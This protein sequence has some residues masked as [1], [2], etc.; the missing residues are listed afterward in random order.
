MT[1]HALFAISYRDLLK[2]LRDPT[3]LVWSFLFPVLLIG[4]FGG[5]MEANLGANT[6]FDFLA[7]TF[8]GVFAQ[9]IFMSAA[10]G[11]VSL[12][13]DRVSDFSQEVFVS[14]VSRYVIVLGK[15][16][17]ETIVAMPPGV[18]IL[19]FG[20][21]VG[22]ELSP[23]MM[24]QLVAVGVFGAVLGGAFGVAL[25]SNFSSRRTATQVVPFIMFPQFFLAGVFTPIRVLPWYLDIL[26]RLSPMRYA[27]DLARGIFFGART[28]AS[29]TVLAS[30]VTNLA[31]MAGMFALFVVVGTYRFV[32]QEQNR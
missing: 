22:L 2:F 18:A 3:R 20:L 12:I 24:L 28:D 14:P 11:V 27:V 21:V 7:F 29:Q 9:T 17:G 13:D 6:G 23:I 8:T 26:S 15:I 16:I 4:V 19:V 32:R 1:A 25:L 31:V 30:P 10:A 5:I